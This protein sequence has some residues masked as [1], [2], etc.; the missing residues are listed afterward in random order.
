[1]NL[2]L[3]RRQLLGALVVLPAGIFLVHC[4]SSDS[5]TSTTPGA[6]P[7][8]DGTQTTYTSSNASSHT[9][10]FVIQNVEFTTPPAAGV[11]GPTSSSS[12][13]THDVAVTMAELQ[14]IGAG[15]H[16]DVTTSSVGH[17]HVFTFYKVA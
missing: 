5:S 12:G 3:G 8:S 9:H 6:P 14:S 2:D 11:S 7:V 4:G 10:T 13:H 1:M 15:Q 17:T 16:I